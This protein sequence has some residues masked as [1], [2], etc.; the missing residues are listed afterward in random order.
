[1]SENIQEQVNEQ[2]QETNKTIENNVDIQALIKEEV[3][4]IQEQSKNEIAGLNRRNSELENKIK[5]AEKAKMTE[6]ERLK[7]E[8]E[9]ARTEKERI[10]KETQELTRAR[11]VDKTLFDAGLP[12]EFAKR[13]NGNDEE[14]ILADVTAFQE[15]INNEA[16]K[17]AESIINERLGGKAPKAGDLPDTSSLQAQYDNAR[18]KQDFATCVAIKRKAQA[19]GVQIKEF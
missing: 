5:E 6:E 14:S 8:L 17:R 18:K 7:T 4:K 2:A 15:F 19:D 3:E 12:Q 13:V 11:I 1:M 10:E 16:E 9:E